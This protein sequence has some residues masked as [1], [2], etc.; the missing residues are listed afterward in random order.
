MLKVYFGLDYN[1][2]IAV[3][4][5]FNHVYNPDWL[6]DPLV[7]EMIKD[8][9]NST[10]LDKYCILSP[11]LGQIPPE[12]LS[13]GVKTLIMLYKLDN[14]YTDL[15]VCGEN[16][17]SWIY[18]ISSLKDITVS[19]SSYDLVFRNIDINGICLNNNSKF[20][21]SSEWIRN[22]IKFIPISERGEKV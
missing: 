3:D 17:E 13:G 8:I 20:K 21:G 6:I 18:K 12:K 16:C 11:V 1:A 7:K 4:V 5:Y 10:V 22:C 9:D 15:M 2:N 19:M 14:F